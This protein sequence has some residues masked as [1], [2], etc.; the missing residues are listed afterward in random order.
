MADILLIPFLLLG[1]YF[2]LEASDYGISIASSLI[3]RSRE[4]NEASLSLLSPCLDG[5]E[6]WLVAA[7]LLSGIGFVAGSSTC[8]WIGVSVFAIAAIRFLSVLLKKI[9]S[10]GALMKVSSLCSVAAL[11][12]L[13]MATWQ[14]GGQSDSLFSGTGLLAG[15]WFIL[16]SIQAGA[17]YGS[18]KVV[19]PLGEHFRAVSLL[20]AIG[21]VVLLLAVAFL[22]PDGAMDR[23]LVPVFLGAAV[24]LYVAAFALLRMRKNAAGWIISWLA[25]AA[26]V[27][28]YV[29]AL[30]GWVT[31]VNGD[32]VFKNETALA[33]LGAA[34]LW[35]LVSL[36]YRMARKQVK[37]EWKDH[38]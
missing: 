38:I 37:Y 33:V 13:G 31:K 36:L 35:S 6:L 15:I 14:A 16:M 3:G 19:N 34:A 5:N 24:V 32:A 20:S 1:V 17:A 10:Q 4:E 7:G 21:A 11:L 8:L 26:A 9:W 12:L 29:T 25:L 18:V 27:A 2:L 28:F 23:A 30:T 22:L